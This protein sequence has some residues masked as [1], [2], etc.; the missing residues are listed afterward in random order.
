[1]KRR[2]I[3]LYYATQFRKDREFSQ[4][5]WVELRLDLQLTV[6]LGSAR[7]SAYR[8]P[9]RRCYRPSCFGIA[10]V[11]KGFCF[12]FHKEGEH[13]R[14]SNC[15][16]KHECPKCCRRYPI[17]IS[18][19]TI[20]SKDRCDDSYRQRRYCALQGLDSRT[21]LNL[22]YRKKWR[23]GTCK[24]QLRAKCQ[25]LWIYHVILSNSNPLFCLFLRM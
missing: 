19:F 24:L 12:A 1:M 8:L 21:N 11:P 4:C 17:Y 14:N 22:R 6:S 2:G 16:W 18:Y 5:S 20:T 7:P 3:W 23:F 9:F 13:C 15:P 25:T 10:A